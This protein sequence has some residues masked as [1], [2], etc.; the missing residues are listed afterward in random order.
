MN[1]RKYVINA[2]S[3]EAIISVKSPIITLCVWRGDAMMLLLIIN[4]Y[5]NSPARIDSKMLSILA[6]SLFK[7][8]SIFTLVILYS[9]AVD[10]LVSRLH[11]IF[12]HAYSAT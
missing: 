3:L 5:E 7:I 6:K 1:S 9:V 8:S 10:C 11:T 4:L 12:F 2:G